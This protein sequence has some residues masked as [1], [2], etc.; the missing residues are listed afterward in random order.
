MFEC[1]GVPQLSHS[2]VRVCWRNFGLLLYCS[3]YVCLQVARRGQTECSSAVLSSGLIITYRLWS[4][5]LGGS[6]T[7][8]V[9]LAVD[10]NRILECSH[11]SSCR[12]AVIN[13]IG[14]CS[15]VCK[16]S[17]S[18]N[19]CVLL[20]PPAGCSLCVQ[21]AACRSASPSSP[22][23][24][25]RRCCRPACRSQ[26]PTPPSQASGWFPSVE[27]ECCFCTWLSV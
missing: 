6:R 7:R 18:V 20:S 16:L 9:W 8:G 25:E 21:A 24:W 2:A 23:W 4:F 15:G 17:H 11:S 14:W 10:K 3:A 19:L 27:L 1:I 13:Q 26:T 12:I 5:T 22:T